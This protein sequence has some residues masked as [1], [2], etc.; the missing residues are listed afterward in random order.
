VCPR[1]DGNPWCPTAPGTNG[2]LFIGMPGTPEKFVEPLRCILW[3]GRK[4]RQRGNDCVY[5]CYGEYEL[6]RTT[7]LNGDEWSILSE[8]VCPVS[9]SS[10]LST[11]QAASR[12]RSTSNGP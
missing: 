5:E 7:E 6:V 11:D 2:Y 10:S 4:L 8:E 9:P 3:V 1:I 12:K